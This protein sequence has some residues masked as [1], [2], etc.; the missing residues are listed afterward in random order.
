MPLAACGLPQ[1]NGRPGGYEG[2][3]VAQ[4]AASL[5]R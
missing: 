5:K 1:G 4:D 3:A 2:K